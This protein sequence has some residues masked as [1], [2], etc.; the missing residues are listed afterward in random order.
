MT[1]ITLAFLTCLEAYCYSDLRDLVRTWF[2]DS[3]SKSG[4]P[5]CRTPSARSNAVEKRTFA[6]ETEQSWQQR[7]Q[8]SS[9]THPKILPNFVD[10]QLRKSSRDWRP[11]DCVLVQAS[12]SLPDYFLD[13]DMDLRVRGNHRLTTKPASDHVEYFSV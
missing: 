9:T 4:L 6:F 11:N 13:H 3:W 7:L 1:L 10:T 12:I 8:G 5:T 2:E